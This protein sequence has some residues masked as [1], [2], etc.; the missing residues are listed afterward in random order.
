M[1]VIGGGDGLSHVRRRKRRSGGRWQ[2]PLLQLLRLVWQW[3]DAGKWTKV[4]TA[5]IRGGPSQDPLWRPVG[6]VRDHGTGC[7][8]VESCFQGCES[9]KL[10]KLEEQEA[11]VH[12]SHE[13][14]KWR[15]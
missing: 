13:Q 14:K 4:L 15:S 3:L 7:V 5:L 1:L 2:G 12:W 11:Y 9:L 10:K 6:R 8:R